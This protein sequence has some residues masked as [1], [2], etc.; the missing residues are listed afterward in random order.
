MLHT[1]SRTRKTKRLSLASFVL[2]TSIL[3][4]FF[5]F[6]VIKRHQGEYNRD[7]MRQR[8]S[9]L[10]P[11]G[12]VEWQVIWLRGNRL[13]S[14]LK[15]KKNGV[16]RENPG[17][18]EWQVNCRENWFTS[19][20]KGG[21]NGATNHFK[22]GK[23]GV[24]SHFKRGKNGVTSH[25]KRWKNGVTSRL[26]GGKNEVTRRHKCKKKGSNDSLKRRGNGVTS[27]DWFLVSKLIGWIDDADLLD[28]RQRKV[29]QINAVPKSF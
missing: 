3:F 13:E 24:T 23:N 22:R 14:R 26:K 11:T 28:Q 2:I 17:K 12:K 29:R 21:K 15:G 1:A 9:K 18:M 20:L 4:H 27:R 7:P 16:T 5:F 6:T 25:F 8:K 19:R 10:T